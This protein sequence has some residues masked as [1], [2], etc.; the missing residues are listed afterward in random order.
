[1]STKAMSHQGTG[2][3]YYIYIS[4]A[5]LAQ[6]ERDELPRLIRSR[7]VNA[8][9]GVD[10]GARRR[11]HGRHS[12]RTDRRAY[13]KRV[14]GLQKRDPVVVQAGAATGRKG[15]DAGQCKE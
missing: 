3:M 9:K 10:V 7:A 13:G 11:C 4:G 14:T 1:M 6:L 8:L 12:R 15:R 5:A 2:F